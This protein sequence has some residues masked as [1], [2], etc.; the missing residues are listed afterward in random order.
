MGQNQNR[1]RLQGVT[2]RPVVC[3]CLALAGFVCFGHFEEWGH[4]R[5][6]QAKPKS[7]QRKIYHCPMHPN[8]TSDKPGNCPICGMNLV[9]IKDEEGTRHEEG[10]DKE[11]VPGRASVRI[12]PKKRQ[13]LGVETVPVILEPLIKTIRTVGVVAYAEPMISEV[14]A[15]FDGWVEK[16][17]VDQTGEWVEKGAPLFAIYSPELVSTQQEFLL[18]M[19]LK[20]TQGIEAESLLKAAR[21]RLAFFDIG[22]DQIRKIEQTGQTSKVLLLSASQRGF[23]IQKNVVE[24][25]KVSTGDSLYTI[26]DTSKV[27]VLADVY[28][29]ALPFVSTGQW[30]KIFLPYEPNMVIYG[31][32]AYIYPYIEAA[33]RTNKVRIEVENP[34]FKLKPDMYAKIELSEDLGKRL[35][36]P[37]SAVL[38]SGTR[39]VAFLDIGDGYFEPKGIITGLENETSYE[40]LGGLRENDR[41]VTNAA[42]LIDS[43]SSLRA[44]TSRMGAPKGHADHEGR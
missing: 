34:H 18:A 41:V 21:K 39:K 40:V 17:Y 5:L 44:A 16:L 32:V 12:S 23:V 11:D 19:S 28:E 22:D 10:H 15:K 29:S 6:A 24:G 13:A 33:T 26:A 4:A 36:V 43:E 3:C 38:D 27:W 35:I 31:R 42:F 2:I 25:K 37:K 1:R 9:P 8:Y 14:Y 30:A 20:K 7:E